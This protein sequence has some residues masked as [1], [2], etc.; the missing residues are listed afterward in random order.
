[1]LDNLLKFPEQ[2]DATRT[3]VMT[4]AQE[5]DRKSPPRHI[6]STDRSNIARPRDLP[7]LTGLSRTTIW[8]L[9]RAGD[10]VKKIRLSAGAVGYRISEI[11]NWL[12]SRQTVAED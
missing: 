3:I 7:S 6:N 1:M 5:K 2:D 12:D 4:I 10:F 8:R 9:E 11:Q